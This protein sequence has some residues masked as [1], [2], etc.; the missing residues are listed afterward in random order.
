MFLFKLLSNPFTKLLVSK[1][2]GAISHKIEKDKVI[3]VKEIES[4][5]DVSLAQIK[6]SESSWK[7]ELLTV[8]ISGILLSAFIPYTQ[9]YVI[10]GFE[11]L[12]TAPEY[13]WYA[14]LIVFSGSFGVQTIKNLKK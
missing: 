3:R 4:L 1:T 8:L 14:V 9:P 2:A 12:K 10:T 11:L 13:F 5:K 6:V 7:D